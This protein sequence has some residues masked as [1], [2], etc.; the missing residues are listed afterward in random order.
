MGEPAGGRGSTAP[1]RREAKL[2]QL[3]ALELWTQGITDYDE[4]AQAV[5]Y[6]N[7]SSA[8]RAVTSALDE[9]KAQSVSDLRNVDNARLDALLAA[10][11]D[12]AMSGDT[13]AGSMCLRIIER[14]AKLNGEDRPTIIQIDNPA[15]GA[16]QSAT[17]VPT[18]AELLPPDSFT[19]QS[20]V[21]EQALA[22]HRAIPR[23]N[24]DQV[25]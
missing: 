13:K 21:R 24:L 7:K 9:W 4:L 10:F 6:A 25:S 3:R 2:K 17:H 18:L 11:W 20:T 1:R 12:D 8:H 5:G 23:A 22:L 14:R 15:A 16:D 19:D